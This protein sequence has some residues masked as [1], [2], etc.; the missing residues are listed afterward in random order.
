MIDLLGLTETE[1]K[2]RQKHQ[3]ARAERKHK[4]HQKPCKAPKK[5]CGG[6]CVAIQTDSHNCGACG[7]SCADGQS[8]QGGQCQ[9]ASTP[10]GCPPGACCEDNQVCYGDG[11]CR[12]GQCQP[13]PT[14]RSNGESFPQGDAQ[15]CSENVSC[16]VG[17]TGIVCTCL[18]AELGNACLTDGD[19][20]SNRCVGYQC[21]GCPAGLVECSGR[22]VLLD[23]PFNCGACGNVCDRGEYCQN[24]TCQ[25][26]YQLDATWPGGTPDGVFVDSTTTVFVADERQHCVKQYSSGGVLQF[27]YG[28]C[29]VAGTDTQHLSRPSGVVANAGLVFITDADSDNIRIF[30]R[31]GGWLSNIGDGSGSGAYGFRFPSDI[32]FDADG[33]FYVADASNNRVQKFDSSGTFRRTFGGIQG[34][35]NDQL[36]GPD[37]VAVD[38]F[39]NVYV[40]DKFNSRV[41]KFDS[42]G[43]FLQ[44]FGSLGHD[45]GQFIFPFGCAVASNG[46]LFVADGLNNCVQ[47][48]SKTGEVVRVFRGAPVQTPTDVAMDDQDNLYIVDLDAGILRFSLVASESSLVAH[49]QELEASSAGATKRKK[50]HHRHHR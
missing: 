27:T 35:G 32:A 46:D 31:N 29:G 13:R 37:A 39:G 20:R 10:Q 4:K 49:S 22:C 36:D 47:Q 43:H 25:P 24:L 18:P 6:Q 50:H 1:A 41:Q 11:R 45:P 16:Q 38:R 8:C 40:A 23:S 19:C 42:E 2:H 21:V 30:A 7:H 12:G 34:T 26:R 44:T 14:C 15:C 28:V 17:T 9:G 5:K 33:N 48:F 3:K